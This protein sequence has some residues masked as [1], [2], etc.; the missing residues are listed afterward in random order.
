MPP[1]FAAGEEGFFERAGGESV[2]ITLTGGASPSEDE[3]GGTVLGRVARGW[4][5]GWGWRDQMSMTE[6]LHIISLEFDICH[7]GEEW[8]TL[9]FV[10]RLLR[11]LLVRASDS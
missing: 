3:G 4:R 2:V 5:C 10:D 1:A 6:L 11:G 9:M 7:T 8:L